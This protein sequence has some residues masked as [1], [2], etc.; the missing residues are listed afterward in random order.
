MI[1]LI[2]LHFI[3]ALLNYIRHSGSLYTITEIKKSQFGSELPDNYNC[4][5]NIFVIVVSWYIKK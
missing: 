1:A 2:N 3:L 4:S 5:E